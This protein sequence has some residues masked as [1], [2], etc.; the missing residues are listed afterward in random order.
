MVHILMVFSTAMEELDEVWDECRKL[1]KFSV[2]LP[3]TIT[4]F[5]SFSSFY[6]NS[7]DFHFQLTFYITCKNVKSAFTILI[8]SVLVSH[9][10]QFH[11]VDSVFLVPWPV[12]FFSHLNIVRD[13]E[14]IVVCMFPLIEACRYLRVC[15]YTCLKFK[16]FS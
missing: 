3:L 12:Y 6:V 10:F 2:H 14:L 16:H 11:L 5:F 9:Y 7:F 1:K 13:Y 15:I 4:F 8:N